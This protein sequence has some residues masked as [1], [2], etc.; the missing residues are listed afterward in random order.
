MQKALNEVVESKVECLK[1]S[2]KESEEKNESLEE[3]LKCAKE[4]WF[5]KL[6]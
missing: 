3:E 5:K 2:L 1:T 4:S 6:K